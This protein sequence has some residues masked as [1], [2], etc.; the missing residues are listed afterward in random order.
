[1]FSALFE[2]WI[3]PEVKRW[4]E[5]TNFPRLLL[6]IRLTETETEAAAKE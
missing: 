5:H 2:Q 4:A 3:T 1:M 6:R